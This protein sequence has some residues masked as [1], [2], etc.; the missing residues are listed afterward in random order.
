MKKLPHKAQLIKD[1]LKKRYR[2]VDIA[3]L[4]DME[5]TA[6][7]YYVKKYKLST[8][9]VVDKGVVRLDKVQ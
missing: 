9:R 5:K 1:L 7:N 8:H 2:Q 3:K 4:L 6:V